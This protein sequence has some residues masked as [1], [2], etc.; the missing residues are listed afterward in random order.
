MKNIVIAVMALGFVAT[1]QATDLKSV[2]Q[3]ALT[4]DPQL[5]AELASAN[6]NAQA[7]GLAGQA[8]MPTL[9]FDANIGTNTVE[10]DS[11]ADSEVD[12]TTYKLTL[13]QTLLAPES[14]FSYAAASAASDAAELR[15]T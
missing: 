11:A 6:A 15:S 2:Y 10:R 12:V 9:T 1:S 7:Q 8:V 3:Q 4:N 13:S 14:W 5:A